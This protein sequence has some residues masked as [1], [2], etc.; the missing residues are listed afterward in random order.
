M[1]LKDIWGSLER[2]WIIVVLS[3]NNT[4][5]NKNTESLKKEFFQV[6]AKITIEIPIH[7]LSNL[8]K[9]LEITMDTLSEKFRESKDQKTIGYMKFAHDEIKKLKNTL[10]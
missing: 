2:R 7:E 8:K 4:K 6:H 3:N 10:G 5:K 1:V 9:S